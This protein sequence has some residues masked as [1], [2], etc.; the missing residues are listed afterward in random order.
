MVGSIPTGSAYLKRSL[1]WC[2]MGSPVFVW[3]QAVVVLED[4]VQVED[5][6]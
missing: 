2:G 6:K 4:K 1:H 5:G 3:W